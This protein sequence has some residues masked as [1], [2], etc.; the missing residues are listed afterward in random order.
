METCSFFHLLFGIWVYVFAFFAGFVC[1]YF[2]F[3]TFFGFYLYFVCFF[4]LLFNM[5]E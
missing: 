4:V 1:I 5:N 2:V 3:P